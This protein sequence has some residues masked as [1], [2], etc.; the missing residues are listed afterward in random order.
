[1]KEGLEL[2][3]DQKKQFVKRA[4]LAELTGVMLGCFLALNFIDTDRVTLVGFSLGGR[5]VKHTLLTLQSLGLTG[6]VENAVIMGAACAI[7]DAELE[8]ILDV[9]PKL[10]NV[11]S[12]ND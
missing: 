9:T 7:S 1:M 4:D 12:Q 10:T 6:L 5:A 11:H 3:L 8:A 2:A